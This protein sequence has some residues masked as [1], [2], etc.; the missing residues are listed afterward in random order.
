MFVHLYPKGLEA[1]AKMYQLVAVVLLQHLPEKV[2]S[3]VQC[4]DTLNMDISSHVVLS[5]TIIWLVTPQ[6]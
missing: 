1:M 4:D 5:S 2:M 6:P 3:S